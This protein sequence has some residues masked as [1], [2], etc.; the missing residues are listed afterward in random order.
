MVHV[1]NA[2]GPQNVSYGLTHVEYR[3]EGVVNVIYRNLF[4]LALLNFFSLLSSLFFGGKLARLGQNNTFSSARAEK[5]FFYFQRFYLFT[6]S[7]HLGSFVALIYAS[8]MFTRSRY[9]VWLLL[10]G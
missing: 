2:K 4:T 10:F 8:R 9:I 7:F 3:R 1:P 5:I 6:R